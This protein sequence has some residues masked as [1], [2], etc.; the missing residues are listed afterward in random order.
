MSKPLLQVRGL[1]KYFPLRSGVFRRISSCIKAV[2]G[3]DF[4]LYPGKTLGIAGESG[5]GKSTACRLAIGLIEPTEGTVFFEGKEIGALGKEFRQQ[6]QI[7]FQDPYASLNPRKTVQETLEEVFSVWRQEEDASKETTLLME[8][9]GLPK[10]MLNRYPHA[11]SG[12]QQQRICIARAL[13]LRPK[14]LVLDEA[15]SALDVSVQAQIL[16]LLMDLKNE[17]GL[18]YL[19]VSHDLSVVKYIAD[20][21]IVMR[22]GKIVEKGDPETLFLKPKHP[23]T[24]ALIDAIPQV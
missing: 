13:A 6:A 4:T 15:V 8:M 12:G 2:D 9:V 16:N 1:K 20:E 7:V 23:Y 21:L 17:L 10:E 24:Q 5:S 19:F 18:S 3:I 11:L 14:L 22:Q